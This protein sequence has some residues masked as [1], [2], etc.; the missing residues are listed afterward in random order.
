[1]SQ[2]I[3]LN[4]KLYYQNPIDNTWW[5]FDEEYQLWILYNNEEND[6]HI[7]VYYDDN[8]YNYYNYN[9]LESTWS[10]K[11]NNEIWIYNEEYLLWQLSN[12]DYNKSVY[13]DI[14]TNNYY[15]IEI[16]NENNKIWWWYDINENAW[17]FNE[18]LNLWI[19][20][21]T[22]LKEK[23]KNNLYIENKRKLSELLLDDDN[24]NS[25]KKNKIDIDK[26][27]NLKRKL[28]KYRE[29]LKKIKTNPEDRFLELKQKLIEIF[30]KK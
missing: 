26:F 8:T 30:N 4:K 5:S 24:N 28:I 10:W 21:E 25:N 27:I 1:M 29:N 3:H 9:I 15:E 13:Y 18:K 17:F 14:I 22:Y 2:F 6:E 7:L 12:T 20:Y 19:L 11:Y 23:K 16:N